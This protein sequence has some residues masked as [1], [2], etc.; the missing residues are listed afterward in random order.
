[1]RGQEEGGRADWARER[2]RPPS[3]AIG[4]RSAPH[5]CRLQNGRGHAGGAGWGG[6]ESTE[7]RPG[8]RKLPRRRG[9]SE[10]VL[11]GFGRTEARASNN[12]RRAAAQHC[13]CTHAAC[14]L[15]TPQAGL[16]RAQ[17]QVP[18]VGGALLASESMGMGGCGCIAHLSV[19]VQ[20]PV[21]V[22]ARIK[23]V[24]EGEDGLRKR[25]HRPAGW[26]AGWRV[27]RTRDGRRDGHRG[28]TLFSR[29]TIAHGERPCRSAGR[30]SAPIAKSIT[31]DECRTTAPNTAPR[32]SPA[33]LPPG[34]R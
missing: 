33:L 23:G 5:F 13:T 22:R 18:H 14:T 31:Q 2:G 9:W 1:M 26:L 29:P 12:A 19:A 8:G 30:S 10:A 6:A 3:A 27:T 28:Q 4:H 34:R 11:R 25:A 16:A 7:G 17:R 32:K 21:A 15:A 24:M 20:R